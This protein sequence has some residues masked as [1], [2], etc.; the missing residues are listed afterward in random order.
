MMKEAKISE[1]FPSLQGEGL[2]VGVPQL[3]V[4]FYGCN[5]SCAF[6]DTKLG[7]YKV[8]TI[9]SLMDKISDEREPYHSI[10]LTGG[11]P[12]VQADFIKD[13]LSKYK[14]FYN[15]P[16]YLE[17]NGTLYQEISKVID[18]IDIVAMDFK[19][20]S[21]TKKASLWGEH[22]KFLKI[23]KNKKTFIKAVITSKTIKR[24]I[25][26][27]LEIVKGIEKDI[28]IVLQPVTHSVDSEKPSI[29][30]LEDFRNILRQSKAHAEI[31]PQVH[32]LIGVK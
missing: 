9:G 18:Y 28:P 6:C 3:F 2:Y 5:L 23:A 31:I 11:E 17:T 19:L 32:K 21:S 26:Q 10:S 8:F 14:K 30:C 4:R 20:P 27:M 12:L 15:K 24:D 22:G 16:I 1:I 13:F 7:S 25:L 29:E